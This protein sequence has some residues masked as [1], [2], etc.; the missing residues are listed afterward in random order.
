MSRRGRKRKSGHRQ[1]NGQLAR[2]M[3]KQENPMALVLNQPHRR[4]SSDQRC[5]SALGR[6]C[7]R[8]GLRR[9]LYDAGL[10]YA[11]VVN[12]WRAAKGIPL[13]HHVTG[14]TGIDPSDET[15]ARWRRDM[16]DMEQAMMAHGIKAL[17]AVKQIALDDAD[18]GIDQDSYAIDGLY[19]VAEN[20]GLLPDRLG[21][22]SAAA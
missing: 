20:R 6:F 1:P 22:F 11:G 9:E 19:A 17:L 2:P 10:E 5:A 7:L 8:A 16:L 3:S 14:G 4:G 15:V 13:Q 12:R 21:P 18:I